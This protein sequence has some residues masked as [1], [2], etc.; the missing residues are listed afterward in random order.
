MT[1]SSQALPNHVC[2]LCGGA[3]QCAP[4][5]AGHL[6]VACWCTTTPIS[7]QALALIPPDL[8]NKACL[9]P[10]CAGGLNLPDKD[11]SSPVP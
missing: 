2:P 7:P 4:A 6:D 11:T 9:C 3:N 1:E 10:R 5:K 8:I